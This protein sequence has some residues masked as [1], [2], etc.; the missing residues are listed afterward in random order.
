MPPAPPGEDRATT[1]LKQRIQRVFRVL[2]GALAGR[3]EPIHQVRIAGRRLRVALPLLARKVKGRRF[4][5]TLRAL[6]A[7]TRAAGTGR[8]MDVLVGLLEDR[9]GAL[10]EVSR[11][12]RELL[13]RLRA[14]RTRSRARM[15]EQVLDVDLHRLRRE[16]R[17]L[18]SRGPADVFTVLT[19]AREAREREGAGLLLGLAEVGDRYEP[20]ALH[21]L[22]GRVRRLR[23][24][25]EVEDAIRGQDSGA[26]A[27]WKR[28]QDAIGVLHDMHL[29]ALWLADQA[30][31]AA[32]R[33]RDVLAATAREE[34]E[35]FSTTGRRLHGELLQARPTE[36]A[37]HALEAMA[38]GRPAA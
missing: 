16:L 32:A 13:G 29:L 36:I 11:P 6:R 5:R 18:R 37:A 19:R 4:G 3:E 22:R 27:A 15:V 17:A 14:A 30:R 28:L 23:Y 31:R 21:A 33:G 12:Q 24:T 25:A 34:S 7:L 20:D 8:D 10:T 9:L 38:R 2:P 26:A 1:L 35:A